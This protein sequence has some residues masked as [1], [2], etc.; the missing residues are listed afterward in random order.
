MRPEWIEISPGE[1]AYVLAYNQF[2]KERFP[3]HGGVI[4]SGE[5]SLPNPL[6]LQPFYRRVRDFV[7]PSC[8]EAYRDYIKKREL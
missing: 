6:V 7:C 5:S 4:L 8:T 2:M 3:H 1:I